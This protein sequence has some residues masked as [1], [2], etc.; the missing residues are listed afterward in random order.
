MSPMDTTL[1]ED[2]RSG[3]PLLIFKILESS[4]TSKY[5]AYQIDYR[6]YYTDYPDNV[7]E[8]SPAFTITVV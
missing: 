8:V 2:D 4:D 6:V 7:I 3:D 1:F 5:G